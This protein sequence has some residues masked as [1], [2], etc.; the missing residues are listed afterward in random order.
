MIIDFFK[1]LRAFWIGFFRPFSMDFLQMGNGVKYP[2]AFKL[3]EIFGFIIVIK[4]IL[5]IFVYMVVAL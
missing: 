1:G 5:S 2:L 4:I 3:G